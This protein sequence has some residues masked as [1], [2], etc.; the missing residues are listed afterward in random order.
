[1]LWLRSMP[2]GSA[3]VR[4][5]L[6]RNRLSFFKV[7]SPKTKAGC[8]KVNTGGSAKGRARIE[9]LRHGSKGIGCPD[10]R[11]HSR[12]CTVAK[13]FSSIIIDITN[14]TPPGGTLQ[15]PAMACQAATAEGCN[16]HLPW[17]LLPPTASSASDL[18][19][20]AAR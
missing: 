17:T 20:A 6:H 16:G 14:G 19:F 12:Q 7:I 2:A 15:G 5:Y 13:G 11:P 3:L 18:P 8:E 4:E 9:H 1:M 10:V